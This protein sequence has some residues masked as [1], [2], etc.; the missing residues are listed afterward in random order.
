MRLTLSLAATL[1][2]TASSAFARPPTADELT[3]LET[4]LEAII[5]ATIARDFQPT[6]D[7][8]PDPLLEYFA[9]GAGIGAA[10]FEGLM[11]EQLTMIFAQIQDVEITYVLDNL[12][13]V[14]CDDGA[15]E[16]NPHVFIPTTTQMTMGDGTPVTVVGSTFAF[17]H[18]DVWYFLNTDPNM[19]VLNEL[20]PHLGGID[21]PASDVTVGE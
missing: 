8:M 12:D 4:R 5:A 13:I 16:C 11:L 2:L 7:E 9:D 1:T 10:E 15:D 19:A 6:V 14:G 3:L 17:E 21:F 18:E 20:Y